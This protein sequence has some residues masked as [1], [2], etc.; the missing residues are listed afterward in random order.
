MPIQQTY[1]FNPFDF[2]RK[3]GRFKEDPHRL[4]VH[5]IDDC[6]RE[7]HQDSHPIA[8]NYFKSNTATMLL[9]QSCFNLNNESF[10]MDAEHDFETNERIDKEGEREMIYAIES[11]VEKKDD[12]P[13]Y[14][15]CDDSIPDGQFVLM[16][17]QE[18]GGDDEKG[19]EPD[20]KDGEKKVKKKVRMGVE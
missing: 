12:E 17:S 10:G 14:L 20:P 3:N 7:F 13:V 18:D 2:D 19:P 4:F 9:L 5:F 11:A 16:Y 15:L 6:Q 1:H 8:A